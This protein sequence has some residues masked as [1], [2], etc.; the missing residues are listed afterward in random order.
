MMESLGQRLAECRA[1]E[2]DCKRELGMLE[3]EHA[4][5]LGRLR[6]R[7]HTGKAGMHSSGTH[8]PNLRLVVNNG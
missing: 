5:I 7:A 3:R 8:Q 2:R 1:E 6:L 4:Y